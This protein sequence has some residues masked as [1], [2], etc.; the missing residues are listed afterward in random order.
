[1][2]S[3]SWD[4][5]ARCAIAAAAIALASVT[6]ASAAETTAPPTNPYEGNSELVPEGKSLFN[7]YCSHCH[8]PDAIQGERPRDLRRLR[9]RY[10]DNAIGVFY[11]TINEG[12]V[13]KGMPPWKGVLKEDVIWRI[14]TFL[15]T[16]QTQP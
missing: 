9:I 11:A 7:Q 15:S 6:T 14:F 1:V 16:V 12:R 3:K 4:S 13:E 5:A 2:G 8:G 10:G